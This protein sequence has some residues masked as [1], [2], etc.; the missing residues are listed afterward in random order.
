MFLSIAKK[1]KYDITTLKDID[2]L[3]YKHTQDCDIII[4]D[5]LFDGYDWKHTLQTL[6]EYNKDNKPIIICSSMDPE[7]I[8]DECKNIGSVH[9][10]NKGKHSCTTI[11]DI[12]EGILCKHSY[13]RPV[14]VINNKIFD[15][16]N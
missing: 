9:F 11:I 5:L 15:E 1:H 7:K 14:K 13:F 6:K 2:K 4:S 8:F 3:T 16:K 10:V 12:I